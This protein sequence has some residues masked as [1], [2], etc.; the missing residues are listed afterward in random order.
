MSIK[1]WRE[2][3]DE[4]PDVQIIT[5]DDV[6]EAMLKEIDHLRAALTYEKQKMK[7]HEVASLVNRLTSIA[8]EY[9]DTGQLRERIAN[10]IRPL[11]QTKKVNE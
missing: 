2:W 7:D 9:H 5:N 8:K 4:F 10:E 6:R 1:T 11:G 3:L